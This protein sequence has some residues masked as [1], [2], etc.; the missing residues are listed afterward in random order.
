VSF[1]SIYIHMP[2]FFFLF[3]FNINSINDIGVPRKCALQET[4]DL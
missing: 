2:S 4:Y 3:L 1:I